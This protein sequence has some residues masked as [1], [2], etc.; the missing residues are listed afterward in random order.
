M[1]KIWFTGRNLMCGFGINTA[2]WNLC[3]C[4]KLL[5]RRHGRPTMIKMRC[6][7]AQTLLAF[8]APCTA[9]ALSGVAHCTPEML[10][11]IVS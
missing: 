5:L 10:L 7:K 11:V 8:S 3:I 4:V 1:L 6:S 2:N 9:G